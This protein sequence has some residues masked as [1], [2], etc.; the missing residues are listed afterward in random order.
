MS[1]KTFTYG[2]QF[3]PD[4]FALVDILKI[5]VKTNKD[6]IKLQDEIA[7]KYHSGSGEQSQ[8]MAMNTVLSLNSYRLIQLDEDRKKFEITDLGKA[9]LQS[10]SSL[11]QNNLFSV[12]ILKNLDGL[13]LLK[14]IEDMKMRG[15][16]IILENLGYEFNEMG[17]KIPPNSTYIS[18]MRA[19]LHLSGIFKDKRGYEIDWDA[20]NSLIGFKKDSIDELYDLTIEQ[21]YYLLALL[22]LDAKTEM[23]SNKVADYV[24][25][26]Y[27]IKITTKNLPKAILE[28]LESK[29]LVE[30]L[31]T[32][33]GRGAKPHLVKLSRKT[34]NEVY[35]PLLENISK[36][37]GLSLP[38][39]NKSFDDV[40]KE[41]DSS[42]KYKKGLALELLSIWIIR[43]LGLHFTGWRVRSNE[44]AGGE[45]D[46]LAANDKIVYNR[47]QIQ[48]KNTRKTVDIGIVTKEIGLTFL[49]EADIV[50]IVTTSSFSSDAINYADKVMKNSR[51]YIILLD[52][53]DLKKI[54]IDKTMI[55]EILNKK[56]EKVF[57]AKE[58]IGG[59][60]N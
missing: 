53:D 17:I 7:L 3:S 4:K 34:I 30:L 37:S 5:C 13:I 10:K 59:G 41:L 18:T 21:K 26:V 44:T 57:L 28:P 12:H 31:K 54:I 8:K 46:V 23:P 47:W 45:V 58:V 19:W 20:V 32:T 50:M 43:L 16:Q 22:N 52:S 35:I 25:S 48:C 56:A 1:K 9:I 27:R 40:V 60:K 2:D 38:G 51:Y 55:V 36:I 11:D 6:R 33:S 49:T 15:E 14:T 42:N 24:R 29:G 39:L